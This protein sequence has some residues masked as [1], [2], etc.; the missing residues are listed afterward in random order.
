MLM[1]RAERAKDAELLVSDMRT[2][3]YAGPRAGSGMS[4]PFG[5]GSP[6]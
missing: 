5:R 1:F 4:P 6:R 3:C 2:R